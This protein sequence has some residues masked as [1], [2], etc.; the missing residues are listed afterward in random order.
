MARQL[1][2]ESSGGLIRARSEPSVQSL[3]HRVSFGALSHRNLRGRELNLFVIA[4][5]RVL[6]L[7]SL[8]S[9]VINKKKYHGERKKLACCS[10]QAHCY[11]IRSGSSKCLPGGE[12]ENSALR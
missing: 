7:G 6:Q 11:R 2:A 5:E 9:C 4:F 12:S 1:Q 10:G 3:D 8:P